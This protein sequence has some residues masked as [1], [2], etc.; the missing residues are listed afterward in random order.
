LYHKTKIMNI[1]ILTAALG[2]ALTTVSISAQ[3]QKTINEGYASFSTDLRGQ[4]ADVKAYFTPDSSAQVITFGAGKV[5]ILSDA[6]RDYLAIV[7][8]IPVASMKKAAIATPAEIE[9]FSTMYPTFTFKQTTDAKTISGF[10]C[11]RVIATDSKSSKAYDIWITN[12]ITVPPTAYAPYYAQAGGYPVQ[13]TAFQQGQ[14]T[15]ITITGVTE[16]KA[17]AGTFGIAKDFDRITMDELNSG[18]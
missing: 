12:D 18:Q 3:A 5:K 13:F 15:T 14:E 16:A 1:K 17:P 7:L 4:P 2:I 10:N 6:K 9:Q 11:K 8:D